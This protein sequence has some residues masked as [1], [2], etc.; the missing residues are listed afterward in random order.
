ML[1][2]PDVPP[3]VCDVPAKSTPFEMKK[4]MLIRA[5]SWILLSPMVLEDVFIH[6]L[7]TNFSPADTWNIGPSHSLREFV[8]PA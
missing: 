3:F 6:T 8:Q 7:K 5:P 2:Q 4:S 1:D